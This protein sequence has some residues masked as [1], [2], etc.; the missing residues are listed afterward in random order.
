MMSPKTSQSRILKIGIDLD[1]TVADFFTVAAPLI[2]DYYGLEPDFKR[3][4]YSIEEAFGIHPDHRPPGMTKDL[5]EKRNLFRH[6]P[7]LDVGI[8]GLTHGI[9][10]LGEK[11]N[12]YVITARTPT[13]IIVEDTMYWL[14]T[15]GFVFTDIFFTSEKANLC[16]FMNI[17]VMME[18]EL[19]HI[20]SLVQT[21]IRVVVRDQPWN[22]GGVLDHFENKGQVKRATNWHEM[23]HAT[24]EF[25]K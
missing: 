7:P 9:Q 14:H 23:L 24:E 21:G 2:K 17:D 4:V 18:D 19:G 3:P 8:G 25:L 12:I 13:D 20:L 16:K 10:A 15:N 22:N 11:I 6:L 1:N 5:L